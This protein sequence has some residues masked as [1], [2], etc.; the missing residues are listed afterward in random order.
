MRTI[1]AADIG[2]T[3]GRFAVFT[4]DDGRT[5]RMGASAWLETTCATSFAEL[6]GQLAQRGFPLAPRDADMVGIAIAGPVREGVRCTPPNIAWDIDLGGRDAGLF[7]RSVLIND[8]T[9]QALA[10]LTPAV[11]E[12]TEI[13]PGHADPQAV[14]AVIGA[15]TALGKAALVPDGRGGRVVLPTEGGHALFPFVDSEE[16]AFMEFV[17]QRT[18]RRMVIG[19]MVVSGPGLTLIHEFLTGERLSAAEVAAVAGADSRTIEWMARLYGRACRDFALS[20]L[21]LGGVYVSGGVAAKNPVLVT[22]RAFAD[23]FRTSETHGALL[24]DMPVRLN[25]NEDSGLWGAAYAAAQFL[26]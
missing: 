21:S 6:V 17:R 1:L 15:G 16:F 24:A 19:D 18:G 10:C 3:N 26:T 7:A 12:A 22:H 25:A 11:E 8:F 5:L 9:A 23:A 4:T 13:L 20:T 14:V 2:G